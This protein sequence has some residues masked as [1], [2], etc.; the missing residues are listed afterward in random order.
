MSPK[1]TLLRARACCATVVGNFFY[2]VSSVITF[3]YCSVRSRLTL[4]FGW[5]NTVSL[6][7]VG[8]SSAR[9]GPKIELQSFNLIL[10]AL[11]ISLFI[12]IEA[13]RESTIELSYGSLV[14]LRSMLSILQVTLKIFESLRIKMH[15]VNLVSPLMKFKMCMDFFWSTLPP[16][17]TSLVLFW[18]FWFWIGLYTGIF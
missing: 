2:L 13:C 5:T 17:F 4:V 18:T 9:C 6:L 8:S 14:R 11:W 3:E 10:T 1:S 15:S 7:C 16:F 12:L